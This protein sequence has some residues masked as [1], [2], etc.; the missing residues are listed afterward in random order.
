MYVARNRLKELPEADGG[1]SAIFEIVGPEPERA[2]D[3]RRF[4]GFGPVPA[5]YRIALK[6][7]FAVSLKLAD[8]RADPELA[9]APFV[10]RSFQGTCFSASPAQFRRIEGLL[11]GKQQVS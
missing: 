9:R 11:T 7:R 4:G 8:M 2:G 5:P 6:A 3:C 10:R 1:I